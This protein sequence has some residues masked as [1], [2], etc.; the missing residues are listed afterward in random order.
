[1]IGQE[2][3][4]NIITKYTLATM[5]KTILFLGQKGCGKHTMSKLLATQLNLPIEELNADT[6][7]AQ[8][9]D[10]QLRTIPYLYLIDLSVI[11]EK[12]QNQFL[13]FIEEPSSN[14]Y[15]ILMAETEFSV[16]NTILS[17][18]VKFK[19]EEYTNEQL[20][21]LNIDF[22]EDSNLA[23]EICKTPGQLLSTDITKIK[24]MQSLCNSIFDNILRANYANLMSL[25]TKFNYKEDYNKFDPKLFLNLFSTLAYKRYIESNC[26]NI[27]L[28][29]GNYATRY[30]QQI[31]GISQSFAENIMINF[32]SGL[33]QTFK[34]VN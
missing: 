26:S 27:Y 8:L 1:M 5:P 11:T 29:V 3:L 31:N 24:A 25:I 16:L 4:L 17:R 10:F 22:G 21:Q 2:K 32:L 34:E 12:Q 15:I 33:Q 30:T 20:A 6:T 13:K 19:F 9:I 7:A 23:F 14:V 28:N 18:C